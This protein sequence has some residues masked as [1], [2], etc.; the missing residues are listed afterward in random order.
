MANEQPTAP[1][2][3]EAV[4]EQAISDYIELG[5]RVALAYQSIHNLP[6]GGTADL[7]PI[8]YKHDTITITVK[9][10]ALGPPP[11]PPHP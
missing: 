10:D 3:P 8:R 1:E 9:R 7:P 11:P 2:A 5:I 4:S 6:P